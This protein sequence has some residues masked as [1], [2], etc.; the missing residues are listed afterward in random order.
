[1]VL[2][3]ALV[4]AAGGA[5]WFF[6]RGGSGGG[7]DTEAARD[8]D[9]GVRAVG[10]A[11]V[12]WQVEQGPSP[13]AI[14][15]EDHWVTEKHLVRRLPGRV[16]AYDLK[17]GETAWELPLDGVAVDRCQSSQEHSA[18]RV[19]LLRDVDGTDSF[20]CTRLTVIDI[21]AGKE[22]FT[23][24]LPS[25]ESRASDVAVVPVVFGERV[26]VSSER[27]YDIN[28]GAGLTTPLAEGECEVRKAALFGAVLLAD[29][30]CTVGERG[31]T[32]DVTRLRAFD[33]GLR[34][35]W[36]WTPPPG[37]DGEPA[38]VLGVLSLDPLVV[39][40][41]HSGHSAQLLRVDVPAGKAVQVKEYAG[42]R[43][44]FMAA[45][46][47]YV[48]GRCDSA[49]VV[50]GK[51]LLMTSPAQV[52]PSDPEA[53]PGMRNTE[54]RNELVAFDLNTG[55]ESWRT[56]RVAGRALSLVPAA[57]EVV[58]YQPANP[59]GT[60]AILFS[61]DPATG[62]LAPLLPIGPDAHADERLGRSL[63]AFNFGGDNHKALWR[64]G[65]FVVF[66]AA[67]RPGTAGRVETVA[68]ALPK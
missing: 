28:S 7:P 63:H 18:N 29:S 22:V 34:L 53:S 33:A 20:S 13:E 1:M 68:F 5:W 58:A 62:K 49:T 46:D 36:E 12:A 8:Y 6:V 52:N 25:D 54:F 42:G 24:D 26:V 11:Q 31:R 27:V 4:A 57:G 37:E 35:L 44:E 9:A 15:V 61:V 66:G 19:A 48:L 56:G 32:K 50:D 67:H 2:V 43:G 40:V 60:N 65:L 3:V 16:V 55:E 30:E 23:I 14:P 59:N 47:G 21:A 51:V 39:E 17:T 10:A 38:P 41:G 64:D 45:C